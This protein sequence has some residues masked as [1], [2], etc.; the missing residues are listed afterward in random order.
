MIRPKFTATK[1]GRR[2][3]FHDPAA[4]YNYM[5]RFKDGQEVDVTIAR[6]YKRRTQGAPGEETNFNGYYWGVIVKLIADE[7]GY[8]EKQ[9]ID[10]LHDWIQVNVGNVKRMPDGKTVPAG[11]SNMSGGDFAE[12]CSK[13]RMWAAAPGNVCEQGMYIPEPNEADYDT[14]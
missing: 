14:G 2:M 13:A 6:K 1:Q 5:D 12:F 4:L 7:M 9:D 11:T 8:F 10:M 3:V